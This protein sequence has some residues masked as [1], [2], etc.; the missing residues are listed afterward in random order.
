M[1]RTMEMG[2]DRIYSSSLIK[3]KENIMSNVINE[4]AKMSIVDEVCEMSN[5]QIANELGQPW[6]ALAI[7]TNARDQL[8]EELVQQRFELQGGLHG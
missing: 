8:I 6:R 4:W 1:P 2:V 3:E 5:A 7:R